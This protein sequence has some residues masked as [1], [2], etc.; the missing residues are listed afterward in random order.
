MEENENK[1]P[2]WLI[3]NKV[4]D[5]LKWTGLT[6]LPALATA[7]LA[8]SMAAGWEGGSVAAVVITAI[9]TFIGASIGVSAATK[10]EGGADDQNN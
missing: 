6:V 5:V 10:K 2:V 1:P 4:Y 3:P 8:V 7:V 9:A